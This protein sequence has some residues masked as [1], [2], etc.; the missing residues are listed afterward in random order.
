MSHTPG[1]WEWNEASKIDR[2]YCQMLLAHGTTVLYHAARWK[3]LK[4][5]LHLIAAAPDLLDA[6]KAAL[7]W[8]ALA[9]ARDPET[10]HPQALANAA[11]DLASLKAAIAK[12]E[13]R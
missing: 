3:V 12:A 11:E 1:P 2:D 8:V 6:L 13:G 10:T 5:D 4:A 9:T 7:P